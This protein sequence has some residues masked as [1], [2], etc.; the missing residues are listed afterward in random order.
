MQGAPAFIADFKVAESLSPNGS[1]PGFPTSFFCSMAPRRKEQ[2]DRELQG[3]TLAVL[4]S[5]IEECG[6]HLPGITLAASDARN[7]FLGLRVAANV[8]S[9]ADRTGKIDPD[10]GRVKIYHRWKFY[11]QEVKPGVT[12]GLD[13]AF[14]RLQANPNPIALPPKAPPPPQYGQA[15]VGQGQFQPGPSPYGGPPQAPP[16][17]QQPAPQPQQ[18]AYAQSGPQAPLPA[19]PP[20]GPPPWAQPQQPAAPPPPGNPFNGGPMQPPPGYRWDAATGRYV[21]G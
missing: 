1:P 9:E 14:Q 11:P 2:A 12:R 4:G 7:I 10:T 17:G 6:Q 15:P 19:G 3:F 16:W 21:Q 20:A 5:T 8:T 18:Y 13:L